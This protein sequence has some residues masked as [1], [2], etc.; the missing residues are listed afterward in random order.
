[1]ENI[2]EICHLRKFFGDK[3][4][5][6]DV[7]LEVKRGEI[8]GYIGANG[9]GKSTTVKI[10]LGLVG[11]YEGDIRIFGENIRD[12]V[13]YKARIGYVPESAEIYENLTAREYLTFIGG[14]YG[15]DYQS[16]DKKAEKLMELFGIADVYD[17]RISSYSKGMKQKTLIISSLLN[18]P[19]ILFLDEP[20]GGIDANSVMVFKEVLDKLSKL[21]KTIFYSSHIMEV[22]EKM[23]DRI[24]LI[25]KGEIVADGS[26]EEIRLKSLDGSLEEIFN[27]LTGFDKH[28]QLAQEMVDVISGETSH[29][30]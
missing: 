27:K 9:A 24:V 6:K 12:R 25:D 21:G 13:D 16:T 30:R 2:I 3:M 10:L 22:V 15:L 7:N 4:V 1:M 14:L 28:S 18:D 5:L 26:L 29:G 8:I 17:A 23:S 19:E 20:L 11:D